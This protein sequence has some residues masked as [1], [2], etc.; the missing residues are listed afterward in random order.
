MNYKF[1]FDTYITS[2]S[3]KIEPHTVVI[4]YCV[5]FDF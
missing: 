2:V 5:W 3:I 1:T 4:H